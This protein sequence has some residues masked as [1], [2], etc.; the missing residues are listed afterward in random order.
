MIQLLH[1]LAVTNEATAIHLATYAEAN[2][3]LP[4]DSYIAFFS[5]GD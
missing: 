2:Y 4:F 3:D 5:S 1:D